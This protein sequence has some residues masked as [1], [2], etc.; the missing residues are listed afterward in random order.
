MTG[1]GKFAARLAV[2]FL[3]LVTW[4]GVAS[5]Q[6]PVPAASSQFEF[7][8]VSFAQAF[9]GREV[10][11]TTSD[12]S[13]LKAR[14]GVVAPTGLNVTAA[15]GQGQTIRF[16][17]IKRI[18]KVSHRLRNHTLAGLIIG[19][20]LGLLGMAACGDDGACAGAL[21]VY[22]GIGT[23]IGALNGAIRNNLNRDDDLIYQVGARTTVLAVTPILSR[24]SRGAALS[25]T[26]R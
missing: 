11:I 26:W 23:G 9:Q 10:W 20:G 3:V 16:A 17:E 1:D 19:S 12:G 7:L 24:G 18:E 6:A 14:I 22:A 21:V 8:G 4:A 2:V 25:L 5:A 15:H 13:R